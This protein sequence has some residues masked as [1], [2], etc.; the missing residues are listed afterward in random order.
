MPL[1]FSSEHM[2]VMNVCD[3][4]GESFRNA[5]NDPLLLACGHGYHKYCFVNFF[6]EKCRYCQS[7]LE[8]GI[9]QNVSSLIAR[10]T[11]HD[12][13][14]D[15]LVEGRENEGQVTEDTETKDLSSDDILTQL[16]KDKNALDKVDEA[17]DIAIDK[18]MKV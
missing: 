4:C 8:R 6:H 3:H 18:F 16:E 1:G 13:K 12:T 9:R 15:N 17:Y 10:I 7:F 5:R 11:K 2:P 14:E